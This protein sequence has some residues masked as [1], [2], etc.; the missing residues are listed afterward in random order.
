MAFDVN[1][2]TIVGRL[3]ADPE[4]ERSLADGQGLDAAVRQGLR[5]IKDAFFLQDGLKLQQF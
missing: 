1:E 4:P 5:I 3:G 2:V